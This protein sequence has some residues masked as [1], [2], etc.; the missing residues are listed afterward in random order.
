MS[1]PVE[2]YFRYLPVSRRTIQWGL[3][4]TGAGHSVVAPKGPS[5][6]SEHP[7]LYQFTWK[8]GR[9]LPEFQ[10][11]YL[12]RGEGVFESAPTGRREIRAGDVVLLFPGVWHRYRPGSATGWET[13]WVSANGSDLHE[14]VEQRFLSPEEPIIQIG[15][16]D[17]V[18]AI[19]SRILDRVRAEP[20]DNPLLLAADAMELLARISAPDLS[21]PAEPATEVFAAAVDDRMVAEAVRFIWNHS[22][23]E[24]TV[25]DV[26]N[27]LPLT[28]RSL[29]RRFHRALGRTILEEIT[30]C[31]V[32]RVKRLLEETE[33][34]IKQVAATAG[35]SSAQRLTKVFHR[36]EDLSPAAYRRKHREG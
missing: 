24:L 15:S 28:R 18:L 3:Y 33:M 30:R 22:H 9:V 25:G 31:R 26:V 29:E 5:P 4:V 19:Y 1:I 27:E 7:E 17:A 12:T 35:F 14:L 16:D 21:E 11:I 13:C 8:K 32:E 34:P 23:R 10:V 20:M 36:L 6:Q 2:D